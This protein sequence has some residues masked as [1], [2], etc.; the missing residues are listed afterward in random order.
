MSLPSHADQKAEDEKILNL[1]LAELVAHCNAGVLSR[2]EILRAYG[3]RTIDAHAATNC[4]ADVLIMNIDD[5]HDASKSAQAN[6]DYADQNGPARP[7]VGVSPH[8][9][10]AGVPVSI[11]DCIDVAEHDSTAGYSV[12]AHHP[13]HTSAPIVRLLADAGAL[14][15]VKTAVPIG[16]LSFE[17][18]SDLFGRTSNP[19]NYAFSPG[20]STGGGAALL[21]WGASV[22]EIATDLGGSVRYPAAWCGLY[23]VKGSFGRFAGSQGCVSCSPGMDGVPSVVSPIARRLEDLREVWER[24]VGMRPWAYDH[25]VRSSLSPFTEMLRVFERSCSDEGE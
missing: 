15:H 5:A 3:R 24:V 12:R 6:D 2:A 19:Y 21:A 4:L 16:L 1:S 9:P 18:T 7:Q 8:K 20:A 22:V 17:T 11:K 13:T 25:S 10:L 23:A 14:M